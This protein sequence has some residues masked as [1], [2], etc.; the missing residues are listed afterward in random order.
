LSE[1]DRFPLLYE[2]YGPR[3]AETKVIVAA[4]AVGNFAYT[5]L[6]T[7]DS[8]GTA[9]TYFAK[10]ETVYANIKGK[11]NG[12]VSD[13]AVIVVTDVD[14][15][16]EVTRIGTAVVAPGAEFSALKVSIGMMPGRDW[17]LQFAMTP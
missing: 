6:Q 3:F 16:V 5:L 4:V 10:G 8:A 2:S 17:K 15:G 11:N 1:F 14:T 13:G 12:P 9:K 7:C